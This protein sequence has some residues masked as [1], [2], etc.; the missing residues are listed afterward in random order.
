MIKL[1]KDISSD[2]WLFGVIIVSSFLFFMSCTLFT[3]GYEHTYH[4]ITNVKFHNV[5][6]IKTIFETNTKVTIFSNDGIDFD[7]CVDSNLVKNELPINGILE[8]R[9]FTLS[10]CNYTFKRE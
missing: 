10:S 5:E 4:K 6:V 2:D 7:V 3:I 8:Y 1:F 9:S